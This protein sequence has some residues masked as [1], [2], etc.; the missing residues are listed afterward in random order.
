MKLQKTKKPYLSRLM[1]VLVLLSGITVTSFAQ[2]VISGKVTNQKDNSA[3]E[4]ISIVIKGTNK[5]VNTDNNGTFSITH[6]ASGVITLNASGV[7]FK[8]QD[9]TVDTK[10]TTKNINIVLVEQYSKL[11]EVV[12]TGTSAGTTKRQLGSY[13]STVSANELSTSGSSNVLAALQ[14]KTAGAQISQ[15]SGDPAGGV[16]VRLRGTSSVLSSSEP[17]YIVDGVIINNATNRVTNTSGNYDGNN[18]VGSIGQNRMVDINPADIDHIEVLNGAA[19]AATYGSRANAGVIQIFTKRGKTGAPKVSFSSSYLNSSLRKKLE[20]NQSP[21]KFGG[22][23]DGPG[24]LT[25]D[26]IAAPLATTTTAV[27]RYDYQDYIFRNAAGTDNT[28][29]ISGGTDKTKYYFGGSYFFNQGIIN[30]TDFQRFSFRTNIDQT[31]NKWISMNLGINYTNSAANEKPDGQSFFSPTNSITIIGNFHNIW[32]RDANGNI[33]AI[34]ERGRV[35]PVSVMEDIKQKQATNRVISN[36]GIKL[37]PIKHLSV[38]YLMGVDNY[39]QNGTTYIPPYAYNASTGFYGGGATLDPTQNGY[40]STASN[41]FFQINHDLNANYNIDITRDINSTTQVGFSQQYEKN[42]Y[43]LFQGRGFAPFIQTVNGA[44]TILPGVDDRSEISVSGTYIQ[45]NFKYRNYLFLTGAI[46]NDG[47][48][49]FGANQRNQTYKKGSL[50]FVVSS[51]DTWNSLG[52]SKVI[53]LFKVRAAYGESGNLTGIGAYSRF[54]SYSSNSFLGRS[55]LNSSSTLANENVKPERQAE[56]EFGLDLGAFNNRVGLTV[57]VYNKKVTDL[58]INRQL[59]P[60]NGFSSVLDNFGSLENKGYELMLSLTPVQT[61][62]LKWEMT[63]IYNHNENKALKIGQ[64]LTLLSTNAGAPVAIIEGQPIGVFYGTYFARNADGS[65]LTNTAGIP[66]TAKGTQTTVTNPTESKDANG[67]PT[68]TVLRKVI[69]NPNP[70]F[71]GS[72]VNEVTYKKLSLRAQVDFVKGVNVFNADFR[73]RQGVGNGKVAEQEQRGTIPR[74]FIT[75]VY[76]IEEWRVD[77][78]DYVKLRELSLSYNLGKV[79]FANNLSINF[80]GR[81]LISWD[82]YKG[83]DPEVNAAGQSTLLRGIDFGSTPI[84]RSFSFGIKADF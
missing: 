30:N 11:D 34:G 5:G 22:P 40:A 16:S 73:T 39:S 17:L 62:D 48:S 68:G 13:V 64:A 57:N 21:T 29:S 67:L 81:N 28:I 27:T 76:A 43:I 6:N 7:G 84:P 23:T 54:N 20:V 38:D 83:Y 12:V 15:N 33:K 8:S 19:A 18:F 78:G 31:V 47:S 3:I 44:S 32:E 60:T 35:N 65:Y 14:G 82:D 59:S 24:A 70:D 72:I 53:D 69:G 2:V 50:S 37:K 51:T 25:Q 61:K 49:V 10:G 36:F 77:K 45:Q 42:N 1:M 9:I 26:V 52:I 58:L 71:T 46:R 56:T 66:Q 55:A 79:A 63:T 74:G 4:G 41:S 80:S 75:G